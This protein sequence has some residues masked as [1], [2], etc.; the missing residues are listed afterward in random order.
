MDETF[1][2]LVDTGVDKRRAC[3]LVGRPRSTYDWR[4]QP[5][6]VTVRAPRPQPA[7]A[8]QDAERE[9]IL[10]M[11][12]D[13]AFVDKAPAQVWARLLDQGTY[14]CSVSTM[15]RILAKAAKC[16][17]AAARPPTRAKPSPSSWHT[18]PGRSTPGTSPSYAD[19]CA[20][21]GTTSTS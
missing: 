16:A 11:L 2:E 15:Y 20:A 13:P 14:L 19:R 6:T 17:S 1:A 21:S 5:K 4:C 10:A 8:L 9:R 3:K 7:N 18:P 12:R